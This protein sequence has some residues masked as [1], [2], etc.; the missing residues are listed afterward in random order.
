MAVTLTPLRSAPRTARVKFLITLLTLLSASCA[1][2][3]PLSATGTRYNLETQRLSLDYTEEEVGVILT[4]IAKA[5][6]VDLSVI[7][8]AHKKIGILLEDVPLSTALMH[9]TKR[10]H[11]GWDLDG[12][13]LRVNAA[14]LFDTPALNYDC[15]FPTAD[16]PNEKTMSISVINRPIRDVLQETAERAGFELAAPIQLQGL[17]TLTLR[18]ATWRRVFRELLN[19]IGYTFTEAKDV[20][21]IHIIPLPAHGRRPEFDPPSRFG[22]AALVP[23]A[24]PPAAALLGLCLHLVLVVGVIRTPLPRPALFAPKWL[25]ALLVLVAGVI[26]LLAYWAIHY[27]P[28]S[29]PRT[30]SVHERTTQ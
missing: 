12:D 9:V 26:P 14:N 8:P 4:D 19:P 5:C 2:P 16:A 29:A 22:W 18:G 25:W 13:I 1:L 28:L 7:K 20:V 24:L 3:S 10:I 21:R 23:K 6:A 11:G 15:I 30:A 27:S 17:A